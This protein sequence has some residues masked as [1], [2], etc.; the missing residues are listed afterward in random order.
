MNVY[1]ISEVIIVVFEVMKMCKKIFRRKL[2]IF[3][4]DCILPVFDR[5]NFD[6]HGSHMA[7][8]YQS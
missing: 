5:T 1:G 2:Q 3:V 7:L 8:I 4:T 6:H